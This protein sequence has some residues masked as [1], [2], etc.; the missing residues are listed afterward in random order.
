MIQPKERHSNFCLSIIIFKS[1]MACH[2]WLF[3]S[4]I[5][6]YSFRINWCLSVCV[7]LHLK[8]FCMRRPFNVWACFYLECHRRFIFC[9]VLL[10]YYFVAI[11][12]SI[13]MNKS[14]FA[15]HSIY[16]F[17]EN[18][19]IHH[20]SG[21]LRNSCASRIWFF[22][23]LENEKRIQPIHKITI[24]M[25]LIEYSQSHSICRLS[26]LRE[27]FQLIIYSLI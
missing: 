6:C 12:S 4:A 15:I 27:Y 23:L 20:K 25:C 2:S 21:W 22:V 8:N 17:I 14:L 11:V 5:V 16:W 3:S 26:L 9:I 18:T 19:I 24:P 13:C 10:L 7:C 1:H